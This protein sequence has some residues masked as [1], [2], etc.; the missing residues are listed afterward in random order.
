[1]NNPIIRCDEGKPKHDPTFHCIPPPPP[2]PPPPSP[3]P[4]PADCSTKTCSDTYTQFPPHIVVKD[5]DNNIVKDEHGG[6]TPTGALGHDSM[7]FKHCLEGWTP[8]NDPVIK[9]ESGELKHDPTFHCIPPPPPSPPPP[10]PPADCS[11]GEC[12]KTYADLPKEVIVKAS[13]GTIRRAP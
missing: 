11:T 1:M 13:R 3:S 5:K 6:F 2:L 8:V 12:A 9:C 10:P 7:H 4:P